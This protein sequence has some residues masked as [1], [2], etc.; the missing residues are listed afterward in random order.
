MPLPRKRPGPP[1]PAGDALVEAFAQLI[2]FGLL[3]AVGLSLLA[4]LG[5]W[6]LRLLSAALGLR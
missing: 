6:L 2:A 3:G 4:W 1:A 5:G